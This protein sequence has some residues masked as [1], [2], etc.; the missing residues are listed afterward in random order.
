MIV[1]GN[2]LWLVVA[3]LWL[4][5]SYLCAGIASCLTIVGI[6]FGVQAFKLGGYALWPFG[7]V[8]VERPNRD[9]AL[10][11]LGNVVWLILGGWWLALLHLVLGLVLFL[12]IV[13][14]PFGVVS[15]R[16]AGLALWPFGKMVVGQ[17]QIP[18]GARVVI[19]PVKTPG[20]RSSAI[21]A[22]IVAALVIGLVY[23]A[24]SHRTSTRPL[25]TGPWSV[26]TSTPTAAASTTKV[27]AIVPASNAAS[28]PTA[29]CQAVGGY[30]TGEAS[31]ATCVNVAYIGSDGSTY[32]TSTTIDPAPGALTGPM[33]TAGTGATEQ[34]GSTGYYPELSTGPGYG[35][36][37]TWNTLLE[38]GLPS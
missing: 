25:S 18:P 34:E 9:E 19:G 12:T 4:G 29:A 1:L 38:A 26:S 6:P 15:F 33:D 20:T 30:V 11:C 14:I 8:V 7:R 37:G 17:D 22:V 23:F 32:Y 35:P 36:K 27:P 3:G 21:A 2:V 10:G 16:M 31:S 13:G 28:V 5:V 24:V